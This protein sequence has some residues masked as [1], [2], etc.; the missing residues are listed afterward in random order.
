MFGS[1]ANTMLNILLA[2]V[3]MYLGIPCCQSACSHRGTCLDEAALTQSRQI[4]SLV[5]QYD[6][7]IL[8][9]LFGF[10]SQLNDFIIENMERQIDLYRQVTA[11]PVPVTLPDPVVYDPDGLSAIFEGFERRDFRI[12]DHTLSNIG[13]SFTG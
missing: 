3:N 7:H 9:H 12:L 11:Q 13:R 1:V 2:E 10:S 4:Y 5:N 8:R 6:F